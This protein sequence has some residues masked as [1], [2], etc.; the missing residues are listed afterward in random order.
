MISYKVYRLPCQL[1]CFELLE[2]GCG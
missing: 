1:L 2:S